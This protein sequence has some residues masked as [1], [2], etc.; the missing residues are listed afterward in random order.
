LTISNQRYYNA[1]FQSIFMMGARIFWLGLLLVFLPAAA[2]PHP[3][4]V[5]NEF[6]IGVS[7]RYRRP[8][9]PFTLVRSLRG[10]A[11]VVRHRSSP[12]RESDKG[13]TAAPFDDDRAGH[14]CARLLQTRGVIRCQP[15]FVYFSAVIPDDPDFHLQWGLANPDP[16]SVADLN[17]PAGW[18][19]LAGS[20]AAAI[21]IIDTGVD[22]QHPDLAGNMWI[23][24]RE[25]P[26]N[27]R[28]DDENGYIDDI[29]G[30]HTYYGSGDPWPPACR[31]SG[32][33]HGT[34]VAGIAAAVGNNRIGISGVNPKARIIAVNAQPCGGTVFTED[35]IIDAIDYVVALKTGGGVN[36]AAI[37]ASWGGYS[38][39]AVLKAAIRRAAGADIIFVA[40]AGNSG[41]NNDGRPFYPA[42][43]GLPNIVAVAAIDVQGAQANFS[44]YGRRS[45]HLAAPGVD[46]WSTVPGSEASSTEGLY[47][48][49][50]GTSMAAPHVSGV[51]SL[52]AAQRPH[53]DHL[54]LITLLLENVRTLPGLESRTVSGGIPDMFELLTAADPDPKPT[55]SPTPTPTASSVPTPTVSPT[56]TPT[57]LPAPLPTDVS[58]P[59]PA[60]TSE[61]FPTPTAG[62]APG[63]DPHLTPQPSASVIFT[64]V[65]TTTPAGEDGDDAA[66]PVINRIPAVS[67]G[68]VIRPRSP[69][70][71]QG[72]MLL[73]FRI[74]A[75]YPDG[76]RIE[77]FDPLCRYALYANLRPRRSGAKMHRL[78]SGPAAPASRRLQIRIPR[79]EGSPRLLF[80]VVLECP[81]QRI[82]S[83][84]Q[85]V[86]LPGR[87]RPVQH[88]I[89]LRSAGRQIERQF[90][91]FVVQTRRRS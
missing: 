60:P 31:M 19:I 74:S 13:V 47:R 33:S 10:G 12:G 78:G 25:V 5:D 79:I 18:D 38:Y 22:Y 62:A 63:L 1:L 84:R 81:Q 36:V 83:D 3:A 91:H 45:V 58:T 11:L 39:S 28:D 24:P 9:G 21:A 59:T 37:N 30:A 86:R 73:Q 82:E 8:P 76:E 41:S 44:N 6:I 77:F 26:G 67:F 68:M 50:S 34:H 49:M 43:Y 40:A 51:L 65:P 69:D 87:V 89:W 72:R 29:H 20:E 53:L 32:D 70:Q 88:R 64:V 42:A 75:E 4:V 2:L 46:I 27:G 90:R 57:T 56:P 23:N 15:N 71:Q 48:Y 80:Y 61:P 66:P 55:V 7:R 85:I 16:D 54:E 17:A 35:A 14:H 52:A